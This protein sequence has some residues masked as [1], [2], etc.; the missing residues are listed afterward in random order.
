MCDDK[1]CECHDR[2]RRHPYHHHRHH[3]HH[4]GYTS[5]IKRTENEVKVP[6]VLLE[7]ADVD[8]GDFLEI[9][10]RKIRKHKKHHH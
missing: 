4:H 8:V 10:I 6:D 5:L 2:P 7:A 1:D 3:I 9:S